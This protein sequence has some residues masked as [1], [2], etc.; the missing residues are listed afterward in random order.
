[1]FTRWE[2]G[3]FSKKLKLNDKTVRCFAQ[4][5]SEE[6]E[7]PELRSQICPGEQERNSPELVLVQ[8]Q[9]ETTTKTQAG[10][11]LSP[12]MKF[13]LPNPGWAGSFS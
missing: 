1:M 9:T 7:M 10:F 4:Q 2:L 13:M 3:G 8:F 5:R 12:G 6:G 11:Y